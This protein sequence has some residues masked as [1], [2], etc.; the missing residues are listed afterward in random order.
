LAGI[1]GRLPIFNSQFRFMTRLFSALMV[2]A[3]LLSGTIFAQQP[4]KLTAYIDQKTY[5]S[6]ETG[7][8]AEVHLQFVGHTVKY[9]AVEGGLQSNVAVSV[10]VESASGDTV[11]RDAY[12][13]ESPVMRDSIIEDFFDLQRISLKP[14]KYIVNISLQD[15]VSLSDP[16]IGKVVVDVPD[17]STNVSL[18]DVMIAEV[19]VRTET[20]TLFS[21]SGY[22]ILPRISNFYAADLVNMPY[23]VEVYHSDRIPD[24]IFALRQKIVETTD[25][26]EVEGFTRYTK[27]KNDPVVPALR[28]LDITKLPTGSYRLE[29]AVVDRNNVQFGTAVS[30]YFERLN[31]TEQFTDVS[32]IVLNPSFQASITDDSLAYYLG[33]LLP[34]SR[35]GDAKIILSTIKEGN[36]ENARKYIQQ[37]WLQTAGTNAYN[38]W[39]DY[40][41]QVLLVQRL[42]STNFQAGY[43]TERGRVYLQYG[44]PNSIIVRETSPSEYPYEIWHYYKIKIYSNKRFVFYNPD[45]VN[46]NYRLLHSDMVGEQQNYRWQQALSKRNSSNHDIDDPNDGNTEHYGGESNYYYR[47]Y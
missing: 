7:S 4:G 16:L 28:K 19:A 3:V 46:N 34:I 6:P 18:S 32:E 13:L 37:Y 47:Q 24:T 36:K 10:F 21:K 26:K 41:Q 23:Y 35:A 17:Y 14:G 29:L 1:T 30:Y 27:L 8:Y 45:L 20:P 44:P 5:F 9:K 43:E 39:I 12:V 25:N 33:S 2:F 11:H 22:D 38:S 31:E 42:Y 40:K 15:V